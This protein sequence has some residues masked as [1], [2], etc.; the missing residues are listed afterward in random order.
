M[1][2]RAKF[3]DLLA[4]TLHDAVDQARR[5]KIAVDVHQVDRARK[6]IAETARKRPRMKSAELFEIAGRS[7]ETLRLQVCA[8]A[9]QLHDKAQDP[10]LLRTAKRVLKVVAALLPAIVIGMAST[11]PGQVSH[12][13]SEWGHEAAKVIAVHHIAQSI[14]PSL[15]VTVSHRGPGLG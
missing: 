4:T 10:V 9:R 5:Y 1:A 14:Q 13:F 8:L 2:D 3:E 11:G 12:D 15:R 7:V 6:A